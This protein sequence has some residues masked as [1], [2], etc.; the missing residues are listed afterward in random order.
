MSTKENLYIKLPYSIVF[1]KLAH[2][3]TAY[4]KIT[5]NDI[6]RQLF[7]IYFCR[8]VQEQASN[9]TSSSLCTNPGI[10][11]S[12]DLGDG[13]TQLCTFEGSSSN[14]VLRSFPPPYTETCPLS[15]FNLGGTYLSDQRNNDEILYE[16]DSQYLHQFFPSNSALSTN[17]I[18][19]N[20]QCNSTTE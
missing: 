18:S 12:I 2:I 5:F 10:V 16:L 17:H 14:N 20:Y 1:L 3:E 19:T 7:F 8:V 11:S 4:H 13:Y 9:L 15:T 6:K